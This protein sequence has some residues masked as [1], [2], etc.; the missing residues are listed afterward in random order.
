[1]S[2]N[3]TLLTTPHVTYPNGIKP[4]RRNR[5]LHPTVPRPISNPRIREYDGM[6]AVRGEY[7][8]NGYRVGFAARAVH[9][10]VF[11]LE[12]SVAPNQR[13]GGFRAFFEGITPHTHRLTR[14]APTRIVSKLRALQHQLARAGRAGALMVRLSNPAGCPR[15]WILPV[16]GLTPKQ[17]DRLVDVWALGGED[18]DHRLENAPDRSDEMV[19]LRYPEDLDQQLEFDQVR[20]CWEQIRRE[21]GTQRNSIGRP[22]LMVLP[23]I[24]DIVKRHE[25]DIDGALSGTLKLIRY[26]TEFPAKTQ[27][28]RELLDTVAPVIWS[29]MDGERT[30]NVVNLK[31]VVNA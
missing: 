1:M 6:P 11:L 10:E 30:A 25:G 16:G 27:H 15:N 29:Q 22:Y 20:Q 13:S 24:V 19:A 21:A 9:M 5:P 2:M 18:F 4:T 31:R 12:V 3:K 7:G 23:E 14:Q 17:A 28:V 8:E 26:H